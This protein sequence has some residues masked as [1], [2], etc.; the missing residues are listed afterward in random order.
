VLDTR[1]A[2]PAPLEPGGVAVLDSGT[3][4]V[5]AATTGVMLNL[6][7]VEPAGRGFLAAYPCLTGRPST[8]N[9]NYGPGDVVANFVIVEPDAAGDV[10]VYT[11]AAT[12]IVVD[13]LGTASTGFSGGAPERL[14]DTRTANLPPGWP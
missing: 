2:G 9:L 11:H 10:C 5:D 3:L 12:H 6:T 13:L 14:L 7:A 8:S 1:Q 4:G